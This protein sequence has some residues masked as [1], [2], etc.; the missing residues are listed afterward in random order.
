MPF[1]LIPTEV[2]LLKGH[3]SLTFYFLFLFPMLRY[4]IATSTVFNLL[5]TSTQYEISEAF[6]SFP[7]SLILTSFS[8]LLTAYP[9][10]L[11]LL[12]LREIRFN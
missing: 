8:F 7:F 11:E 2:P 5:T 12:D 10:Q 6:A 4:L 9:K 3:H 1:E